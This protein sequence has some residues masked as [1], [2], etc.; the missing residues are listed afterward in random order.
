MYTA[1]SV[2]KTKFSKATVRVRAQSEMTT[3]LDSVRRRECH[4]TEIDDNES[5]KVSI[6]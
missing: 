6:G 1:R 5:Q 4:D 3:K 2:F